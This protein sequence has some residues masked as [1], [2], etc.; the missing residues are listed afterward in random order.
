MERELCV[1][2]LIKTH[3]I[4]KK[5]TKHAAFICGVSDKT[6]YAW[7]NG[8]NNIPAVDLILLV[9][10]YADLAQ[11]VAGANE[12]VI[13][14]ESTPFNG[15]GLLKH[16]ADLLHVHSEVMADGKVT[17]DEVPKLRNALWRFFQSAY[18]HF[19]ALRTVGV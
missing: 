1:S 15:H 17:K 10:E 5:R 2:T 18:R 16:I 12:I 4:E 11:A 14:S 8:Q 3:I 19:I 13:S 7:A 6:V 9:R